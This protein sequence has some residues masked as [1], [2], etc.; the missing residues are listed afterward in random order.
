MVT[1]IKINKESTLYLE[2]NGSLEEIPLTFI[3]K[4]GNNY[5]M[6]L[7]LKKSLESNLNGKS[8][9]VNIDSNNI[10]Y[11]LSFK[12]NSTSSILD[13][14]Y[15]T[16]LNKAYI[17]KKSYGGLSTGAIVGIIIQCIAVLIAVLGLAFF[18][19]KSSTGT[20]G[21][22]AIPMENMGN[23]TIGIGSSTYVVNK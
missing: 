13:Y 19:S 14:D 17:P 15:N 9:L 20:V 22:S 8:G 18:L 5:D 1:L 10:S 12:D 11:I 3:K 23:N 16:S 2:E 21:N 7:T 4:E 6:R